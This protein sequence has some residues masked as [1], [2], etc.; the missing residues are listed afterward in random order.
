MALGTAGLDARR[1]SYLPTFTPRTLRQA[2]NSEESS[3]GDLKKN[4]LLIFRDVVD[5][6]RRRSR[7]SVGVFI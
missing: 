5:K 3:R 7:S 6:A 1:I 2:S 4:N